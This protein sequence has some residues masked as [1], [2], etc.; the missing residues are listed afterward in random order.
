MV[1]QYVPKAWNRRENV[2]G[3]SDFCSTSLFEFWNNVILYIKPNKWTN[4][5]E[6]KQASMKTKQT[7]VSGSR[8]S[9]VT[10]TCLGADQKT[11]GRGFWERDC[12]NI[13]FTLFFTRMTFSWCLFAQQCMGHFGGKSNQCG[14]SSNNKLLKVVWLAK[15]CKI[16][17]VYIHS[18]SRL[19]L[20]FTN[21]FIHI[22][23]LS[24]HSRNIFVYI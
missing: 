2:I 4:F 14:E 18:H 16:H 13:S 22:Q 10:D 3:C 20:L 7:E 12:A 23:Q 21:I 1:T 24:L 19:L 6:N 17:K 8:M 15:W 5:D 11:R 9:D